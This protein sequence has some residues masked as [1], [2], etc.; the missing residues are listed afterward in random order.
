MSLSRLEQKLIDKAYT[1]IDLP[2][3][4]F[5]H[6]TFL[7]K[8]NKIVNVSFN[9]STKTHPEVKK[10]GYRFE[11]VHAELAMVVAMRDIYGYDFHKM[12]VYNIRINNLGQVANSAPCFCCNQVLKMNNFRFVYYTGDDG[13]FHEW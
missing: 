13:I 3:S 12:K 1:L 11:A 7:V 5:K 6:F 9:H 10:H 8:R 4:R 2:Q